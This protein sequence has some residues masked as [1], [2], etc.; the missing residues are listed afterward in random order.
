MVAFSTLERILEE[1]L[2]IHSP[3]ALFKVEISLR[4]PVPLV[5]GLDQSTVAQRAETTV[6]ECFPD[7]LRVSSF[8]LDRIV[9]PLRLRWIKNVCISGCNLPPAL[10][11]E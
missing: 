5:F 10:L 6:A 2:T 4:T 3:P 9:S 8:S 1:G 11:A 7:E